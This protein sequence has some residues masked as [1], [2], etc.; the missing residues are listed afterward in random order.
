MPK[1]LG[2]RSTIMSPNR[3][4]YDEL[5]VS[6][7]ATEEEIRRAFRKLAMEWHPDRNKSN[8]AA[9]RFKSVNEAYQILIDPQKRDQYDRYGRVITDSDSMDHGFEGMDFPTTG[10]GD[11]FDAFFGGFGTRRRENGQRKGQDLRY[12]LEL[13]L[14]EAVFGTEKEVEVIRTELCPS[15][16]GSRAKQGTSISSCNNCKGNGQVRRAQSGFFGQFVQVVTCSVC[17]GEGKIVESPCQGCNGEGVEKQ[18][19]KINV[20]IPPGVDDGMQLR[21]TGEAEAGANGGP[22]GN[23]YIVLAVRKHEVFV[24]SGNDLL[25]EIPVDITQASLGDNVSIP[26]LGG[27]VHE[28]KIPPG[29]QPNATLRLKEKGVVSVNGSRRGDLLVT[30]KVTVPKKLSNR[31]KKLLNDLANEL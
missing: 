28:L 8:E 19:R 27:A 10:F 22:P 12:S 17:R 23:L 6:K 14:E 16:Q 2:F 24:R 25:L 11:I 1:G 26:L 5:E 15:C 13:S 18:K 7:D 29:V 31:A 21:V 20:N 4:Y 3:S 9:Q 30:L